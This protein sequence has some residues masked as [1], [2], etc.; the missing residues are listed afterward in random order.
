MA[1]GARE[2]RLRPPIVLME[3][4]KSSNAPEIRAA[5]VVPSKMQLPQLP[6]E[7]I[8]IEQFLPILMASEV[9]LELIDGEIGA[10]ANGAGAHGQVSQRIIDILRRLAKPGSEV[11]SSDIALQRGDAPT[12]VFPDASYTTETVD[13]D[14]DSIVAP[15]LVVEVMSPQSVERDRVRKLDSYQ[16]IPSV[17]EYL[18]VDSRRIWACVYRRYNAMWI[19]TVYGFHDT[20]ELS[21]TGSSVSMAELYAGI[22]NIINA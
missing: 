12:Y 5:W 1:R 14:V 13:P 2:T 21:T 20:I 7:R 15:S 4:N 3:R 16:A 9:K 8:S 6:P 10:F 18:I 17:Q 19:H 22:E 11:F